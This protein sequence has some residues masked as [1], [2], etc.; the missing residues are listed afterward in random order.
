MD[1]NKDF[2]PEELTK[3][4]EQHGKDIS[5]LTN[6]VTAIEENLKP[7]NLALTLENACDDSKKMDKLFSKLFCDMMDKDESV[8]TAVAKRMQTTDRNAVFSIFKK[9]G[10]LI[11]G[12]ILYILGILTNAVINHFI[13]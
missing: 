11:G 13:H 7:A 1:G 3:A 4:T 2:K 12:A 5:D 10:L 6:R 9:W 8:K